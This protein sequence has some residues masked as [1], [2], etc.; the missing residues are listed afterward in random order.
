MILHLLD[1][2]D[3]A[4]LELGHGFV[5]VVTV[6][7]N[8]RSARRFRPLRD[9]AGWQPISASGKIEDQPAAPDVGVGG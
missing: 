5:D 2:F 4:R 6:E 8:A 9:S 3:A 7:G 1:E